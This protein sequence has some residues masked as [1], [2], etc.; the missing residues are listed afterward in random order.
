VRAGPD[1]PGDPACSPQSN[2]SLSQFF[3][4]L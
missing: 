2:S 1:V 3:G 4:R